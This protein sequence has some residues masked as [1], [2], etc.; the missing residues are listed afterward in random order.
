MDRVI[1][2]GQ[3]RRT[4]GTDPMVEACIGQPDF[5]GAGQAEYVPSMDTRSDVE[6]MIIRGSTVMPMDGFSYEQ[7]VT[8]ASS[9]RTA[10][11]YPPV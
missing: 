2:I 10:R 7:V 8:T 1:G 6:A 4:D 9:V 3:P 5:F 11:Q